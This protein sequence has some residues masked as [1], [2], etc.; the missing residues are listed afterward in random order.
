ME[1]LKCYDCGKVA[2]DV[3]QAPAYW[4]TWGRNC[5]DFNWEKHTNDTP[6]L[7]AECEEY[8]EKWVVCAFCNALIPKDDEGKG[9]LPSGNCED[10]LCPECAEK[11]GFEITV[12]VSSSPHSSMNERT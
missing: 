7:C 6:Q 2:D 11:K 10:Y 4:T 8:S 9:Y 5:F 3:L 1:N 12:G